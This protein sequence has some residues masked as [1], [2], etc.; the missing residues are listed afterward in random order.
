MAKTMATRAEKITNSITGLTANIEIKLQK[1]LS[2][3]HTPLYQDIPIYI[4]DI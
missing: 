1:A 3:N 4:Q 2:N